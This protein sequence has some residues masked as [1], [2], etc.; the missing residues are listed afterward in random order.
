MSNELKELYEFARKCQFDSKSY[1]ELSIGVG[2]KIKE[3]FDNL[4]MTNPQ[5]ILSFDGQNIVF[6][7]SPLIGSTALGFIVESYAY[8]KVI[9]S[10]GKL[11]V[12]EKQNVTESSYDFKY[13]FEDLDVMINFKVEKEGGSNNGVAALNQFFIDYCKDSKPK[14]FYIYKIKYSIDEKNGF[15]KFKNSS[16]YSVEANISKE[17]KQD[18]RNWGSKYTSKINGRFNIKNESKNLPDLEELKEIINYLIDERGI[19]HFT[20]QIGAKSKEID[21]ELN[22]K[23]SD[24]MELKKK[25]NNK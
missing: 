21:I 24:L 10:N 1:T 16:C 12:E 7:K 5:N 13:S 19:N 3:E 15:V 14:L 22:K 9:N 20:K 18:S 4:I 2:N 25:F 11:M 23:I 6:N 8:S 17:V